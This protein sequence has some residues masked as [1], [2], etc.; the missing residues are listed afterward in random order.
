MNTVLCNRTSQSK[1][2]SIDMKHKEW[3]GGWVGEQLSH[4]FHNQLWI[5]VPEFTSNVNNPGYNIRELE[6]LWRYRVSKSHEVLSL[7]ATNR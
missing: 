3:V 6:C 7:T 5:G 2:D 4:S 1:L